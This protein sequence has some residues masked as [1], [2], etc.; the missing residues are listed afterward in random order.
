MKE[1]KHT[2]GPWTATESRKN[3]W[4]VVAPEIDVARILHNGKPHADGTRGMHAAM[5]ANARL[6]AAAPDQR[7]ALSVFLDQYRAAPEA[8]KAFF[9]VAAIEAE[10]AFAKGGDA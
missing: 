10:K 6:I 9:N 5:R 3:E 7:A 2:P 8:A 4:M 1:A